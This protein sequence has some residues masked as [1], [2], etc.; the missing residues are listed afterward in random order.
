MAFVGISGKLMDDVH[1]II[2]RMSDAEVK[3][4]HQEIVYK[5]ANESD[6]FVTKSWGDNIHLRDQI[7]A[8]WMTCDRHSACFHVEIAPYGETRFN[9]ELPAQ[10]Q[11]FPPK[12]SSYAAFK[13]T[14]HDP[15][16]PPLVQEMIDNRRAVLEIRHRWDAIQKQVRDFLRNCK[17]LNE[18]LK[19]WPELEHYIPK[20]Y[21]ERVL[22]KRGRNTPTVSKAAE[23]LGQ[24]DTQAVVASAVIARMAGA[25]V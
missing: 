25:T 5:V 17:S 9:V 3:S 18:A 2:D 21:V 15:S 10:L 4:V 23:I 7:P 6:W 1:R 24:I 8:E 16:I 13:T 11:C 14:E 22:E 12:Y 20:E 19:L